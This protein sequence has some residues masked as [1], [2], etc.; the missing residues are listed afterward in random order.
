MVCIFYSL[1]LELTEQSVKCYLFTYFSITDQE[2]VVFCMLYEL[3]GLDH[4]FGPEMWAEI[5]SM[6][7]WGMEMSSSL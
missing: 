2:L 3:N 1:T 4:G 6:E 7:E 5:E